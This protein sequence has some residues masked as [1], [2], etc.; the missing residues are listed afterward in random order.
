MATTKKVP[1]R[2][3]VACRQ[4]KPKYDLVRI[5]N[6][7]NGAIVDMTGKINGRGVY[8]C[9]CKECITRAL[10][11]KKFDKINGFSLETVKE[12]LESLIEQ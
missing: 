10:K 12:Q 11:S 8:L 3:C 4:M 1:E 5:V 2:M 9:K 7:P 6:T